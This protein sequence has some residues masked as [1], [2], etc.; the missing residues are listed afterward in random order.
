MQLSGM[1]GSVGRYPAVG[2][3]QAGRR[4]VLVISADEAIDVIPGVVTVLPLTTQN[5]E[6][7]TRVPVRGS[8][9]GLKDPSWAI[10]E[11]VRTVSTE[12]IGKRLGVADHRTLTEVKNVLL[13]LLNPQ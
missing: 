12:R 2:S 4:P 11:Q 5:R 6:W 1:L 10:C 13:Y 3:E 8:E 7:V 9:T